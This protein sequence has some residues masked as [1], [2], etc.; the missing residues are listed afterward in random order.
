MW[1]LQNDPSVPAKQR[2]EARKWALWRDEFQD[3]GGWPRQLYTREGRRILGATVVTQHDLEAQRTK[4]DSIGMCGY[5]IDIREVQWVAVRVFDFPKADDEVFMEGYVSQPVQPWQIPYRALIPRAAEC[6]NLL[7]PVCA[8]MSTIAY[9]SFRM[10]PG[11]MIVGHAAG[12]AAALAAKG[13]GRVQEVSAS[14]LQTTLRK[15]GQVLE[16]SEP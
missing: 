11:Y 8:S 16:R 14:D 9:A 4:E 5:N 13:A 1:F 15:Q 7:V 12:V 3:A 6:E 10:D 2:D